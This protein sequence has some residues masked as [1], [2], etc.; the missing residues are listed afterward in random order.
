MTSL[1]YLGGR[2]RKARLEEK[3]TLSDISKLTG[4]SISNLSRFERGE[5]DSLT[6][7]LQYVA[8]L[9][10][11]SSLSGIQVGDVKKAALGEIGILYLGGD[12][13]ETK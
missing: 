9:G 6:I 3:R 12:E 7:F 4:I 5:R 13:D 2:I 8:C 1:E 10:L 11:R